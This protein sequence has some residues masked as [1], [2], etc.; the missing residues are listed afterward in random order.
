MAHDRF[1]PEVVDAVGDSPL[2]PPS[3]PPHLVPPVALPPAAD[4]AASGVTGA[5]PAGGAGGTRGVRGADPRVGHVGVGRRVAVTVAAVVVVAVCVPTAWLLR[6]VVR[7]TVAAD[8]GAADP[9]AAV[10]EYFRAGPLGGFGADDIRFGHMLCASR[11]NALRTQAAGVAAD[12][13]RAA[14]NHDAELLHADTSDDRVIVDGDRASVTTL[15]S[16]VFSTNQPGA[17][18]LVGSQHAWTFRLVEQGGWRV[19]EVSAPRICGTVLNCDPP[20]PSSAPAGS[21]PR[22]AARLR[23]VS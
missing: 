15:V 1:D 14:A 17:P 4:E 7:G 20:A 2:T 11:R 13:H 12:V 3:H 23:G 9:G 5:A 16:L 8:R 22:G 18:F 19:C 10:V 6:D 21:A